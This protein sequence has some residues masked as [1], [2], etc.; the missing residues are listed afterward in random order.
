[1]V[2]FLYGLDPCTAFCAYVRMRGDCEAEIS[3]CPSGSFS[4]QFPGL[5]FELILLG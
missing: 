1:M 4:R 2:P 5:F 3:L